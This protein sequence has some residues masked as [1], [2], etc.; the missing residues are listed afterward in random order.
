MIWELLADP[1]I[2]KVNGLSVLVAGLAIYAMARARARGA[3]DWK[4]AVT[5]VFLACLAIFAASALVLYIRGGPYGVMHGS[6]GM[7]DFIIIMIIKAIPAL[8][9]WLAVGTVAAVI[10]GWRSARIARANGDVA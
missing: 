4:R 3:L 5:I 8:A 2:L 7:Q 6:H 9:A 10:L 1:E